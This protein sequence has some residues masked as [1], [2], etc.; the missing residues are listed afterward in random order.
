MRVLIIDDD[1]DFRFLLS[2]V[3][4]A[5]GMVTDAVG[6]AFGVVNKVATNAPPYDVVVLD[7]DLPGLSGRAALE[8]L[9]RDRRT[10]GVPVV[11]VTAG[12]VDPLYPVAAAHPKCRVFQKNGRPADVLQQIQEV[13]AR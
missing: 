1:V 9:T 11:L 4:H 13:L 10:S 5:A 12:D 7:N 3:L 2:R 8:M 6:S